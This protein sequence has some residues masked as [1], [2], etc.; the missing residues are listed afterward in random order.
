MIYS[1]PALYIPQNNTEHLLAID[2]IEVRVLRPEV[3]TRVVTI[4]D[5]SNIT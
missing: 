2:K 3:T 1:L 5:S 4:R